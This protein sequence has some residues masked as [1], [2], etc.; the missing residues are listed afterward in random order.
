[1]EKIKDLE[2]LPGIG[3]KTAEK[4][5]DAGFRTVESIAVA[6]PKELFEIAE[7][8]ESSAAK[9]IEAARRLQT[10]AFIT[11]TELL[12]KEIYW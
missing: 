8:G 11:A 3:P 12:E 4:L 10:L 7:I 9:I 1:M 6:S 5:R 2:D